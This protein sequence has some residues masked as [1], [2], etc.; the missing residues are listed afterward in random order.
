MTAADTRK[1]KYDELL[2]ER[3]CICPKRAQWE[4]PAVTPAWL[5]E[6]REG[7]PLHSSDDA[8]FG[9]PEVFP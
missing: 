1:R 3:Y 8:R 6:R 9:L 7:C 2:T 5:A 4:D